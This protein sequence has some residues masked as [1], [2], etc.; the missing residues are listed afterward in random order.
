MN[1]NTSTFSAAR[2]GL[3]VRTPDGETIWYWIG[4][5]FI[6]YWSLFTFGSLTHHRDL[7]T[8]GGII[9]LTALAWAVFERLWVKVDAVVLASAAAMLIP[10]THWIADDGTQS[11][12]AIF[13][14]VSVC[15]VMAM[16]RLLRLPVACRSKFRWTLAIP[17]VMILLLSLVVERGV[18]QGGAA[19]HSGLFLN[20]NNLALIPFL[21]LFLINEDG[22]PLALRLVAHAI[23]AGVLAFSGTSGAI[24]AYA[25]GLL[26]HLKD[27]LSPRIRMAALTVALGG[28]SIAAILIANGDH[29]LPE[30][31]ITKQ[32]S[33]ILS[34]ARDALGGGALR[35]YDEE[36]V[37]GAGAASGIWRIAHWRET[38]EIYA[39]GTAEQQFLGFG[40]GSSTLLLDQNKLPHNEYLRIIFEQGIV[41]LFL[42]LFAWRG[43]LIAAPKPVRYVG[44]IVAIYSFSENNLD[45]FPFMSL[46]IL[47]L[48]ARSAGFADSIRGRLWCFQPAA[49]RPPQQQR[50]LSERTI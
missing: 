44:L 25:I 13:K 33:L 30:T 3:S 35:Y 26:I 34:Q 6:A 50:L 31:R 47:F 19:R 2:A 21:L 22:D 39:S 24:I 48:S 42:F 38:V 20:P 28:G 17:I 7:N 45:N 11:G 18:D 4:V 43:I 46:F 9:V 12:Q 37:L 16:S 29:L 27:R 15:A 40:T 41:G 1:N 10:L 49:V 32:V 5:A 23:V 36:R 14:Y 8:A